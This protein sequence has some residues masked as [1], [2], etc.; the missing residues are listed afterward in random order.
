[1]NVVTGRFA[2]SIGSVILASLVQICICTVMFVN[3][4]KLTL[5]TVDSEDG[6]GEEG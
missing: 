6:W 5:D 1:M 2:L 3:G 4:F